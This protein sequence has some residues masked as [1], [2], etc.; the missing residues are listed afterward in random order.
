MEAT[1][2]PGT[3]RVALQSPGLTPNPD[4]QALWSAIRTRARWMAYPVFEEVVKNLRSCQET[5]S[6]SLKSSEVLAVTAKEKIRSGAS[7]TSQQ[8]TY[9]LKCFHGS[10]AYNL[11][12]ATAE[13]FLA[14]LCSPN[15]VFENDNQ[16]NFGTVKTALTSEESTRNP[17]IDWTSFEKYL[18]PSSYPYLDK[19]KPALL[20]IK[21]PLCDGLRDCF[22]PVELIW[23]YWH[24]EGM[25]V[26]SLNAICLRFQNKRGPNARDPLANLRLDPLRPLNTLLWGY[27]QDEH[28]R[29]TVARRAYEYDHE[30]G[31]R[32]DGKSRGGHANRGQPLEVP[33]GLPQSALRN[34]PL[35][36]GG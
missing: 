29:L 5:A 23:S 17:E 26:Q 30:Y 6:S 11:L 14:L 13:A 24:E 18:S 7:Q 9:D 25:L 2:T 31:L 8:N 16:V 28:N 1:F 35:L 12:K 4:Q 22:C 15:K 19:I 33:R 27:I 3:R 34:Q 36:Q 32:L 20:Q 10:D 21:S